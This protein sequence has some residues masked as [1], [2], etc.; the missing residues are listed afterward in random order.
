MKYKKDYNN[1]CNKLYSKNN[2][3]IFVVFSLS[4]SCLVSFVNSLY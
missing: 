3:P 1:E 2:T 4:T